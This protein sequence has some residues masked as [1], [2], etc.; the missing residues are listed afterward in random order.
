MESG[1]SK[2]NLFING[3]SENCIETRTGFCARVGEG[4]NK[5]NPKK[6]KI[7]LLCNV[8]IIFGL[9]FSIFWMFN[10]QNQFFYQYAMYSLE[11]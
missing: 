2:E 1:K 7:K 10:F 3:K 9:R 6:K 8:F 4:H 5:I 11:Q